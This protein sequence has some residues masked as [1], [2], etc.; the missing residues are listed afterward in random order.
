MLNSNIKVLGLLLFVCAIFFHEV[1][2]GDNLF[3][4]SDALSA[5]S[6]S[7]GVDL[8]KNTYGEYPLWMP[9]IFSGIPSTHSMQNISEYY[10]PHHIISLIKLFG[11]PW[12]WNK[13]I[14]VF[15]MFKWHSKV[16]YYPQSNHFHFLSKLV[17]HSCMT[18]SLST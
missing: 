15:P 14:H 7:H 11:I 8:A 6:I 5:K 12:F 18:P 3:L 10:F 2:I 1:V 16:I 17:R 9:W 13:E 4:S